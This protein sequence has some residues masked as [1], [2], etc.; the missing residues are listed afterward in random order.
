MLDVIDIDESENFADRI[1][2]ILL[3]LHILGAMK[4][5][6]IQGFLFGRDP[7]VGAC[8]PNASHFG[9]LMLL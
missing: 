5:R 6:M 3:M 1:T 9:C 8:D 4:T 2:T 7:Q